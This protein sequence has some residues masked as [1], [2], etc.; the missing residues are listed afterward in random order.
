VRHQRQQLDARQK[1]FAEAAALLPFATAIVEV[2]QSWRELRP[3]DAPQAAQTLTNI[4][5]QIGEA[6]KVLAASE[7]GSDA[8]GKPSQVV[9]WRAA[10]TTER[11]SR[12]LR[13][14]YEF[15]AS[16]D[17]EFTW[18][19][20]QPYTQADKALHEHQK[21]LRRGAGYNDNAGDDEEPVIGTPIGRQ[22]LLEA[23]ESEMIPYSPEELFEIANRELAWCETEMKRA[24]DDLGFA[25]DWHKALEFV[26]QKYVKPG[27]QPKLIKELADEALKFVEDRGLV[28]VPPLCKEVWRM[29]MMSVERQKVS[30]YFT[31]GEVISVSYPTDAMSHE[32]KL[33]SMRGN[34]PSFSRAT[35]H[36][37]LIP[38][39][40]LQ[41]FMANRYNTHRELFSTPFLVEGWALYWEMLLWDKGFARNAEDR[42]GML[43]WRSHRCARILF[44]LKFHLGEMT[45]A[46]AIDFLVQRVGH[47]RRN[48]TAEV[49]RSVSGDYG[50]L[51]QAA[52]M[53]GGQQIRALRKELVDSGKM[54]ERDFHDAI[55]R[56]NAIPL[57]M[58]R[59]SLSGQTLTR[60]FKTNWRFYDALS[61]GS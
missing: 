27:E 59:A 57:E 13:R 48:A 8:A 33:M 26:S 1:E 16:Y 28:T 39:H 24:A 49:R 32:D 60:D 6:Q 23:L 3:G 2:Q 54:N 36:H 30:P 46:E 15:A 58:I 47:E 18:W 50:P 35:V 38:G 52:Y 10:R 40:H 22:A 21:L 37:E 14:W 4:A 7:A 31:G 51:Y 42:V 19:A 12:A 56:E 43:F 5:R 29:D 41:I 20:K 25:G 11:L 53:L 34:N 9:L 45:P 17:P 61:G 44:S 55:L